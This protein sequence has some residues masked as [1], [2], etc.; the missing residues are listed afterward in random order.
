MDA[1]SSITV[2]AGRREFL[3]IVAAIWPAFSPGE[4]GT[5]SVSVGDSGVPGVGAIAMVVRM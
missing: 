4:E 2:D 3:E 5:E 1:T